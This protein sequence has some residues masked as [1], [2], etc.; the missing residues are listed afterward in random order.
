V[1]AVLEALGK[2]RGA[3]DDRIA[4]QRFHDALQE[5]CALL[6]RV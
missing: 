3:E 6:M 1:Q 5:G 2:K 4:A